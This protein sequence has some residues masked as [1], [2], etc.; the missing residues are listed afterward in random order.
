MMKMHG[1]EKTDGIVMSRNKNV[2]RKKRKSKKRAV[3]LRSTMK[4]LNKNR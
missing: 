4:C 3:C 1:Q 2:K